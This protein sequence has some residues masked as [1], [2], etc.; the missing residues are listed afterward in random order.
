MSQGEQFAR[1]Q[2]RVSHCHVRREVLFFFLK[3]KQSRINS[4][5]LVHTISLEL[6]SCFGRIM[7]NAVSFWR[8]LPPSET[9]GAVTCDERCQLFFTRQYN[10]FYL[11]VQFLLLN[12]TISFN[13]LYS[14]FYWMIQY[15]LV[16]NTLSSN[17]LSSHTLSST[18]EQNIFYL[19]QYLLLQYSI[20]ISC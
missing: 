1:G 12:D 13:W 9:P 17:T 11:Q 14:M 10:I 16:A 18:C 20:S 6:K 5:F 7:T 8:T 2:T 19:V 15:L 3:K 4:V